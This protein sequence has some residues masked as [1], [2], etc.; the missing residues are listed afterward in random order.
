MSL[1]TASEKPLFLNAT[2]SPLR[3]RF[4]VAIVL[5]ACTIHRA[6]LHY[7][8]CRCDRSK[9]LE[10]GESE[11]SDIGLCRGQLLEFDLDDQISDW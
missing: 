9:L 8:A 6:S 7:V 11:L 1:H 4:A 10:M 2:F 5:V 3:R